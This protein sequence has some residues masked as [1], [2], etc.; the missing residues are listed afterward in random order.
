[1]YRL[2]EKVIKKNI[3]KYPVNNENIEGI[4]NIFKFEYPVVLIG[5]ISFL[6]KRF[7]KNKIPPTR[8]TKGKIWESWFGMLANIKKINILNVIPVLTFAKFNSSTKVASDIIDIK[9]TVEINRYLIDSFN[10]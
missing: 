8:N 10:R 3:K 6:L 7:I 2:D 1:M 9:N 5:N 4:I